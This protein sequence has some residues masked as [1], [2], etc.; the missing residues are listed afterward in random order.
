MTAPAINS[1]A[2]RAGRYVSAFAS[3]DEASPEIW[4]SV[5]TACVAALGDLPERANLGFVYVTAALADDLGSIVTFLRE[6]TGVADWTG[7]VGL[8]VMAS[9]REFYDRP[10]LSVLVAA[11]PEDSYRPFAPVVS[12]LDDFSRDHDAWVAQHRPILGVVHGD[13]R[14]PQIIEV[15]E[16]VSQ[17]TAAFLVG[18]LTASESPDFPQ[19][20]GTLTE[21]G[22]SGVL[23][24]SEQLAVAG[25]SQG[26]TP[27]GA[28]HEV[29]AAT[30]QGVV[31]TLDGR[32]A[33]T[34]LRE[35][36][37]ELLS[38]D[39]SR[40]GGYIFAA[41]PIAGS[42]TGD[43]T[44]RN[45][46]GMDMEREWL[47]VGAELA[48]GDRVGFCRRDHASARGDLKRMLE[49]LRERAGSA[50]RAGLYYSCVAR[51]RHLFGPHS[52]ELQLIRETFGDIPLTGFFANGEISNNRLYGYTG[53]LTLLL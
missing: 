50:P 53:V 24:S 28:V 36:V 31:K 52:E 37:G 25:L 17:A 14:N 9:G 27:I 18:G 16:A 41:L 42:D 12:D 44:V 30:G 49:G 5:A 35:D 6:R 51:G 10:A 32:P 3:S 40:I 48:P 23:F 29:T 47:Q 22:L 21:G 20:C 8:G 38:R 46:V 26:C 11:L 4:G 2:Q 13:P 19:V 34:V 15:I 43:Y 33:L 7:T 1:G 45:L 39:L